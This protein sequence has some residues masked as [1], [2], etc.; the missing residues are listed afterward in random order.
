MKNDFQNEELK[1]GYRDRMPKNDSH[2]KVLMDKQDYRSRA[3]LLDM[4]EELFETKTGHITAEKLRAF[5]HMLVMSIENNKDD[6]NKSVSAV[7]FNLDGIETYPDRN[8][9]KGIHIDPANGYL[10]AN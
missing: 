3:E 9:P 5:L 8:N 4:V 6:V 7:N 10:R 2:K 1:K